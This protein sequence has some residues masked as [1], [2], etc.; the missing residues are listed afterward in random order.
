[1]RKIAIIGGIGSGKSVVSKVL[2]FFGYPVYDCDSRAKCLMD[3]S[4]QIHNELVKAFGEKV[5]VS[6][7]ID[8]KYLAN[9]VFNDKS[10]LTSLNGIVHPAVKADFE[11]WVT[12]C[13]SDIV[14]VETAILFESKMD[15][16]VDEIWVVDA[17]IEERI[18][19]VM[20][21]DNCDRTAVQAR[22]RMQSDLQ[23][24][25]SKPI[26]HIVNDDNHSILRQICQLLNG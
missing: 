17:P 22:I 18:K 15:V 5:I 19:R 23:P 12:T 13:K 21:R 10:L 8:R 9:L 25:C 11:E 2:R 4:E 6:G 1:M 3:N 7:S 20:G 14:F 16:A 24:T 26:S